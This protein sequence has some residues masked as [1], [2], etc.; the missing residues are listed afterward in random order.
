MSAPVVPNIERTTSQSNMDCDAVVDYS[1]APSMTVIKV[2][3]MNKRWLRNMHSKLTWAFRSPITIPM[4]LW[5]SLPGT[6]YIIVAHRKFP[7]CNCDVLACE[8]RLQDSVRNRLPN[9]MSA[10]EIQHQFRIHSIYALQRS[11]PRF[12]YVSIRLPFFR[13]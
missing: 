6:T 12:L 7:L 8:S 13:R 3:E 9:H 4:S 5:G 1:C 11:K 2:V 10:A